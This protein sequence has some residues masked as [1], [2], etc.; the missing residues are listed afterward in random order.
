MT[1]LRIL[2]SA[3]MAV[4]KESLVEV[5]QRYEKALAQGPVL[6]PRTAPPPP[7]PSP[8]LPPGSSCKHQVYPL[9]QPISNVQGNVT[10]FSRNKLPRH[11]LCPP[12]RPAHSFCLAH[13]Q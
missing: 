3:Y 5:T 1:G 6:V 12:V 11:H 2:F 10:G 13:I 8:S 4:R 7:H 9:N